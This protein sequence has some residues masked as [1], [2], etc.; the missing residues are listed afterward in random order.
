M[1]SPGVVSLV[2]E[3]GMPLNHHG[4]P[5]NSSEYAKYLSNLVPSVL[6]L[7]KM[8]AA[9]EKTLAHS[10]SR[11]SN[12]DGDVFKMAATAKTVRRMGTRCQ[13]EDKQNGG[14]S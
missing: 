13:G 7:F 9:R 3:G 12:E 14:E 8:A 4:P 2:G 1:L 10:R 6:S 5:V 11:V